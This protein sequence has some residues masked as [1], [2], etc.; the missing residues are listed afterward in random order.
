MAS[1]S[2]PGAPGILYFDPNPTTAKLATAG[3]QLAGYRVLHASTQEQAVRLCRA[4]GPGGDGTVVALLLDTATSPAVAAATLR[5]LVQ[6]PGAT[7]LPGVLLVSRA[8]PTPI[9]GA[10]GLPSLRRPFTIPALHKILREAIDQAPTPPASR[11]AKVSEELRARLH[12]VLAQ[13]GIGADAAALDRLASALVTDAAIPTPAAGIALRG[14]VASLRLESVLQMLAADGVRG[15]LSVEHEDRYVRLHLD[16]SFI[17]LAEVKGIREEDLRLGRFVVEDGY[18]SAA[19]VESVASVPDS[20]GRVLGQ[21]LVDEGLLHAAELAQVLIHQAREVTC[22]L[23]GWTE[24]RLT[25]AP[26]TN[27][28]PL[29][30]AVV[31]A[32]AELRVAEA[33]LDA[34]RRRHEEAAM[35]PHMAGVDDVYVRIDPEIAKMG[36]QAFTREELEVLELLNGRNS[37]KEI[38]RKSRSGTFAVATVL[39][40][41]S[42]S[43]LTRRRVEPLQT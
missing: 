41:L 25:F 29:A 16:Q 18:L 33:L 11:K 36:R 12:E 28:H 42:R 2:P 4:H 23:L 13:A 22:Q 27:L 5:A 14:N 39:H 6:V 38:A 3:M 8:N 24:G 9:P 40:R 43:G 20:R 21:R 35:G 32:K 30:A 19:A 7:E 15:V 34:L 1:S 17:R 31:E 26:T 10:E 37:V